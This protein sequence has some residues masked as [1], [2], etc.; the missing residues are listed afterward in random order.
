MKK[1]TVAILSA[2]SLSALLTAS[3]VLAQVTGPGDPAVTLP[4][5]PAPEANED[6]TTIVVTGTQIRGIAPPGAN[7]VSL[8]EDDIRA[9]GASNTQQLLANL[10]QSASFNNLTATLPG[11]GNSLGVGRVPIARPNI[12]KLPACAGAGSGACTL[13]LMDGH[14]IVPGG[15]EQIAVDPSVIPP[16]IMQRVETILDGNSAIYGSDAIGGVINFI[17]RKR[18]DG[19]KVDARYGLGADYASFDANVTGGIDWGSGSF[20][21]TYSYGKNDAIYGKDRDYVRSVNW[22]STLNPLPFASGT[23]AHQ[24]C[25]SPNVLAGGTVR[26]AQDLTGAANTC[27]PTDFTTIYPDNR[28]HTAY[29]SITQDFGDA[30][31]VEVTGFY[32]DFRTVSN[33]GP[34]LGSVSL[35]QTNP[36]YRQVPGRLAGESETVLFSY[37]PVFGNFAGTQEIG[38]KTWQVTPLVRVNLGSDWQVRALF[39]YGESATRYT[40]HDIDTAA[41]TAA[42]NAGLL[43]PFNIGASNAAALANISDF[44][45]RSEGLSA[46]YNARAIADGPLFDIG[47]GAVRASVGVEYMKNNF[48]KRTT[49]T[50]TQAFTPFTAASVAAWSVFGEV[51]APIF[52]AD[53][54]TPGFHRL[55]LSASARYDH[56]D[57]GVGG[58]FNPKLA[59]TWEPIDWVTLRGSWG[60]SFNA[61]T[62]ADRVGEKLGG[63][64][65]VPCGITTTCGFLPAGTVLAGGVPQFVL[66]ATGG[67]LPGLRPQ[68]STNW[69]VGIDLRP[70]IVPNL[71]LSLTY[72]NITTKDFIALPQLSNNLQQSFI[73]F[74]EIVSVYAPGGISGAL[75]ANNCLG[76]SGTLLT[77]C[78]ALVAFANRSPNGLASVQANAAPNGG[79]IVGSVDNWVRNIGLFKVEGFDF[80]ATYKHEIANGQIDFRFSGNY[81]LRSDK[82]P[83]P[84]DPFVSSLLTDSIPRF[85][86]QATLG[87]TLGQVRGQ[88]TWNHTGPT[89]FIPQTTE[90]QNT[91]D[92]FDT[93]DLFFRLNIPSRG[94]GKSLGLTLTANNV[95]DAEPPVFRTTNGGTGFANNI[96]TLGRVVLVGIDAEF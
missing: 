57:G 77:Q 44:F 84:G 23:T 81:Q 41:Q 53:N 4:T 20:L 72:Y 76:A 71:N 31:N 92:S 17:T 49:L 26:N 54:A 1:T 7:I 15:I 95:F 12:R 11:Q 74:P 6:E 55:D 73:D 19:L 59:I 28:R 9:T 42:N 70:P 86:A 27:D 39:S 69:A 96:R 16:G 62:A 68:T 90:L 66:A 47:G 18:Y 35:A 40:G 13:I 65:P 46:M 3:P 29:A 75:V 88:V 32:S 2:S 80:S 85:T 83:H 63:V 25:P 21:A 67:T 52:G 94:F 38:I 78:Q 45:N 36:F 22:A 50:A 64:G 24:Q 60:T 5:A 43:N 56:Y 58:T 82:A 8:S 87:A 93:V 89:R 51:F 14:R 33:R 61:P 48:E 34:F 91:I 10:P 30:I 79:V 37:G